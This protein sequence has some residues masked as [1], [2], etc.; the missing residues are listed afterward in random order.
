MGKIINNANM[1][2]N[3]VT[4]MGGILGLAIAFIMT[5]IKY[6]FPYFIALRQE[7]SYD[8]KAILGVLAVS[9]LL[10]F[11]NEDYFRRIFNR[12]D[13]YA[14]KVTKTEEDEKDA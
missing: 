8:W 14:A 1:Q 11:I 4:T 3:P 5:L 2:R 6:V 10:V 12:G 13:K 7:V 9:V